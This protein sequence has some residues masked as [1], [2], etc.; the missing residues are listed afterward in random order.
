[1]AALRERNSPPRSCPLFDSRKLTVGVWLRARSRGL[2]VATSE[3]TQ[4]Q[5][6]E[7]S[8]FNEGEFAAKVPH[9]QGYFAHKKHPPP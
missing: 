8:P 7:V 1:M 5:Y 9:L 4:V 3:E 6:A 2:S